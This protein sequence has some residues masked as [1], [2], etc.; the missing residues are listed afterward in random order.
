MIVAVFLQRH[1]YEPRI[2]FVDSELLN[3]ESNYVDQQLLQA[4]QDPDEDTV[5]VDASDW[6]EDPEKWGGTDPGISADAI[7][8]DIIPAQFDKA[9]ILTISFD[10]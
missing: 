5:F 3:P 10:C 2:Q 1:D 7:L 4:I 9:V 8:D 6:E